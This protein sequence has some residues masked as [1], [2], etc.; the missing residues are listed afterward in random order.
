MSEEQKKSRRRRRRPRSSARNKSK[1]TAKSS[2]KASS[3][4]G[5]SASSGGRRGRPRRR[6]SSSANRAKN[7]ESQGGLTIQRHTEKSISP[8][9]K[10]IFIYTYTLR[11]RSL[12]DSYEAGPKV[13]E[14][15]A[16]EQP[17]QP[18]LEE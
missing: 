3:G 14:K 5:K 10:D 1:S 6:N 2:P 18:P 15:M 8:I 12:L 13:A 4:E 17:D 9:N 7:R 16:F 11:P